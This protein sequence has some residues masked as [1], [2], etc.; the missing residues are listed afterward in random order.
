[1]KGGELYFMKRVF[2]A[3][4]TILVIGCNS[5]STSTSVET[6]PRD[7]TAI[8]WLT[9]THHEFGIYSER[10]DKD[11]DF[12]FKNVGN[13]PLTIDEV[14]AMCGC[15]RV[16]YA[17]EPTQ[18]GDTGVIHVSYNGNGFLPGRYHKHILMRSNAVDSV[19]TLSIA[20][21]Y[22]EPE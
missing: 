20:G 10:V 1:M 12:V 17:K 5:K 13:F 9:G 7:T 15:T 14:K 18:P 16:D 4:I 21:T 19:I 8:E 6:T 11:F 2:L 22:T 3:L